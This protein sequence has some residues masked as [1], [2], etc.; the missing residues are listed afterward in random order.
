MCGHL[1][2]WLAQPCCLISHHTCSIEEE[3]KKKKREKRGNTRSPLC[4][5]SA[6]G[7]IQTWRPSLRPDKSRSR[8]RSRLKA[9]NGW[10]VLH[11]AL[12]CPLYPTKWLLLHINSQMN[13]SWWYREGKPSALSCAVFPRGCYIFVQ[14][15]YVQPAFSYLKTPSV[16]LKRKS[17][18]RRACSRNTLGNKCMCKWRSSSRCDKTEG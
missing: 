18:R 7:I 12:T 16:Q 6:E 15:G 3:G 13:I 5:A 11:Y 2:H 1:L 17:G 10:V 8:M 9:E 4:N 14:M